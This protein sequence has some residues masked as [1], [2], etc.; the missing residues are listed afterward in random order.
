MVSRFNPTVTNNAVLTVENGVEIDMYDSELIIDEGSSLIIGDS[1]VFRAKRGANKIS[2]YGNIQIG[3]NVT[4][5]A[6]EGSTIELYFDS[7]S[8]AIPNC[9]FNNCTVRSFAEP[10]NITQSHF[11]NST[12]LQ[13]GFNMFVSKSHFENS[14]IKALNVSVEFPQRN[15]TVSVDSCTFFSTD[16][17]VEMPAIDVWSYDKFFIE[18]NTINGY[19]N[20]IQLQ[21]SGAGNSGNQNLN[22]NEIYNSTMSGIMLFNSTSSISS[23]HLHNNLKGL[24]IYDNCN[25]A[26]YGNP[27]AE[28]YDEV[29]YIT[30]NDSYEVYASSGSLPWKS[31]RTMI[32]AR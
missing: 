20:G 4:F 1:V 5:T 24:S 29:N 15:K 28:T 32:T 16:N 19:Y 30:N 25:V 21:Y 2:I 27:G 14:F 6:D 7:G 17:N 9:N 23:N 18:Y 22:N 10:L 8:V 13:L 3:Y 31:L 11:T 12:V 26:L